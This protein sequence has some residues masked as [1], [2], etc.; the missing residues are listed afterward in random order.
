MRN[1]RPLMNIGFG[2]MQPDQLMDHD[3]IKDK[4]NSQIMNAWRFHTTAAALG[5]QRSGKATS[6]DALSDKDV[7]SWRPS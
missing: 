5:R 1:A 3:P 7:R 2:Y 4:H 6:H